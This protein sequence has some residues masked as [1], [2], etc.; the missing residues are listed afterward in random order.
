MFSGRNALTCVCSLI[1]ALSAREE[2]V[3]PS[4]LFVLVT[5]LSAR[6]FVSYFIERCSFAI[7]VRKKKK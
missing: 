7:L 4:L 2:V 6:S 5:L 3:R 1:L